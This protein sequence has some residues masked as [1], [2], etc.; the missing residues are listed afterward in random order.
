MSSTLASSRKV[1]P[2]PD[3]AAEKARLEG[4][5]AKFAA[6]RS[7]QELRQRPSGKSLMAAIE[8]AAE[9]DR[10]ERELADTS[11]DYR[12]WIAL[13]DSSGS[14]EAPAKPA[15][16][17]S[18]PRVRVKATGALVNASEPVPA[19]APP[20]PLQPGVEAPPRIAARS[21][22][23]PANPSRSRIV[24]EEASVVIVR[25]AKNGRVT[26]L[27]LPVA[28]RPVAVRERMDRRARI[29]RQLETADDAAPQTIA[30]RPV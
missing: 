22:A 5:L 16:S 4:R 24:P 17:G 11:E 19:P 20:S 7:L 10:L 3:W 25:R 30:K 26:R 29:E 18:K 15:A 27:E 13:S 8:T 23:A 28:G 1:T 21:L 6:W 14:D 2:D 9:R 12:A